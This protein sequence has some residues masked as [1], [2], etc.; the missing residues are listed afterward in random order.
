VFESYGE[1]QRQRG[2]RRWFLLLLVLGAL[3]GTMARS[4]RKPAGPSVTFQGFGPVK[5][6]MT[7]REAASALGTRLVEGDASEPCHY[8]RPEGVLSGLAFMVLDGRIVRIDVSND[9]FRTES[10]A[11]VGSAEREVRRLHPE[12]AVEPHPYFEDGHYLVLTSP[13]QLYAMIFETDGSVVTRF[14]AGERGPVA[15]IEGCQ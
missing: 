2:S 3:A 13:D 1:D 4:F 15:Y 11:G 6:G 12:G 9:L 10:G 14:R 8:A 7:V 5:V